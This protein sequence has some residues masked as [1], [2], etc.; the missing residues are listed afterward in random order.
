MKKNSIFWMF[1]L[2]VSSLISTI[3][4]QEP[5]MLSRNA[6]IE[7]ITI[8]RFEDKMVVTMHV[9]LD[10]LKMSSSQ[11]IVFTPYFRDVNG[12]VKEMAQPIMIN[13]RKQHIFY[14]RNKQKAGYKNCLAVR[15]INKQKQLI[16]YTSTLIYQPWMDACTLNIF[17]D[18]CGCGLSEKLNSRELV[19]FHF[20]PLL[21][22]N[23]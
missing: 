21:V 1:L 6:R 7:N 2:L 4:A 20:N 14:L 16:E 11:S 10:D 13:G 18:L 19:V 12:Q 22:S 3:N 15:R 23:E 9:I 17:E 8:N 5:I